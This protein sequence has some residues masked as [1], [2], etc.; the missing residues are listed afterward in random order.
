MDSRYA[1]YMRRVRAGVASPLTITNTPTSLFFMTCKCS[2]S[3]TNLAAS[4]LF[5]RGVG[6]VKGESLPEDKQS[7]SSNTFTREA[8]KWFLITSQPASKAAIAIGVSDDAAKTKVKK[9]S[10]KAKAVSA[11]R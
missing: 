10:A 7:L 11:K 9:P 4:T 3:A 2:R 8:G 1:Q 5:V 6:S